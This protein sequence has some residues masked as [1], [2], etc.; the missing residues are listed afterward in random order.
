MHSGD[1]GR[2]PS[3][4][5]AMQCKES[6]SRR[7]AIASI[8]GV[9]PCSVSH[10]SFIAVHHRD[11][12]RRRGERGVAL[13]LV[14]FVVT[15]ASVIVVN[16]AYSTYLNARISAGAQRAVQA[17]YLLKSGLS[18][19]QILLDA[20][21]T[22]QSHLDLWAQFYDGQPI[23]SSLLGIPESIGRVSLEIRPEQVRFDIKKL[24]EQPG[25]QNHKKWRAKFE[26]LFDLLGF[27]NDT[28]ETD[29][30]GH[31]P[32]K[33]FPSD[34][35]VVS[36]IE[37]MDRDTQSLPEPAGY[38]GSLKDP[39]NAFPNRPIASLSELS[40]VPGF[41]PTRINKL[42]PLITAHGAAT[43]EFNINFI[44]GI[45]TLETIIMQSLSNTFTTADIQKIQQTALSPAPFTG[46]NDVKIGAI[47]GGTFTTDI[48]PALFTTT[49]KHFQVIV[50][51][52]YGTSQYFLRA[53]VK[54]DNT[55]ALPAVT[56][57]EL[58]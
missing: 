9:K 58:F 30:S 25:T 39:K 49:S 4:F 2:P 52:D 19:A 27:R 34:D 26:L 18:F 32:G 10:R 5:F 7:W 44:T 33:H 15:L 51:V 1:G 28:E 8:W 53:H 41:S 12:H 54:K 29:M 14:I 56:S 55:G 24:A 42:L 16:L 37:Y 45:K 17:E 31:F 43:G 46:G 13:I 36:L 35:L 50:N 6:C 40:A 3:L 11:H 20:A 38:E 22:S 48:A 47:L 23:P 57:L 21:P